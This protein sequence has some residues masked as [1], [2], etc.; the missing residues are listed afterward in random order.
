MVR[1]P[2]LSTRTD[3]L[4]PYTTLFR[5]VRWL[6]G[7][8]PGIGQAAAEAIQPR[9]VIG[10]TARRLAPECAAERRCRARGQPC[11][12]RIVAHRSEEHTSELQSL[13]RITY[14]VF[15]LKKKTPTTAEHVFTI[16]QN[17]YSHS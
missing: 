17:T 12:E 10:E 13:M 3:P 11:L 16:N 7:F 9:Q 14:A 15:C 5:S 1:R 4:F 6:P 2:P 8:V